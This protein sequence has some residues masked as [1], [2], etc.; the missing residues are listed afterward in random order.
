MFLPGELME[1]AVHPN[2]VLSANCDCVTRNV[3]PDDIKKSGL[4]GTPCCIYIFSAC[5]HLFKVFF[6]FFFFFFFFC[7]GR[8]AVNFSARRPPV[9]CTSLDIPDLK[10][11]FD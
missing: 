3:V 5:N 11:G 10:H 2:L 1:R 4:P 8:Q 9:A 6:F 7:T